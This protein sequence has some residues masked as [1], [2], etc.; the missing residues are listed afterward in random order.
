MTDDIWTHRDEALADEDLIGFDAVALDEPVGTVSA[1]AYDREHAYVVVDLEQEPERR[2]VVPVGVI[3]QVDLDGQLVR[4]ACSGERLA[5]APE[6]EA[7]REGDAD[8]VE[9]LHAYWGEVSDDLLG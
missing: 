9:V 5:Q 1:T 6:Y 7:P 3:D 2:V 8:Y 4:L